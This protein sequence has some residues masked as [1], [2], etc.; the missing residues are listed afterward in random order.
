MR[1]LNEHKL[2]INDLIANQRTVSV[3]KYGFFL[4]EEGTARILL[5]SNTYQVS[6]N[7][8]CFYAPNTLFQILEKSDN[9]AGILVEDDVNAYYPVLSSINIRKRLEVRNAPCVR[10]SDTQALEISQLYNLFQDTYY[11]QDE[12]I[13]S[14]LNSEALTQTIHHNYLTHL[15]F[16]LCLKVLEAYFCN[17]PLKA[18]PLSTKD[19]ILNRFLTSVYDNCRKHRTVHFYANEQNLSSYYFSTIIRDTSGKSALSWINDITMSIS[20]QY[21]KCTDLSIKE[22]ADQL[23]FPD[24]S[25]FGRFFKHHEGCSPSAFREHHP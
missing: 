2:S 20:K 17:T 21:L 25:S 3:H 14:E 11:C 22:I 15:R 18:L 8:L 5:G 12:I 7:F 10:I 13:S 16:A 19:C 6:R 24:Q 23:N 1:P 4:C 9:L